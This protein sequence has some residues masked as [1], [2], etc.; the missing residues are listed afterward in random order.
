MAKVLLQ[1]DKDAVYKQIEIELGKNKEAIDKDVKIIQE[2]L[3]KQ[4]HLPEIAGKLFLAL[5]WLVRKILK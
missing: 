4:P 5:L 1:L 3:K 2:W